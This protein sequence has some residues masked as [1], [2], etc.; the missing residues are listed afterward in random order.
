MDN[1]HIDHLL[2][3]IGNDVPKVNHLLSNKIYSKA[4]EKKQNKYKSFFF[5]PIVASMT[6]ALCMVLIFV[7]VI[8][9]KSLSLFKPMSDEGSTNNNSIYI[10]SL[11]PAESTTLNMDLQYAVYSNQYDVITVAVDNKVHNQKIYLKSY[12]Y[13]IL[14]VQLNNGDCLIDEVYVN[15]ELFYVVTFENKNATIHYFDICFEK[16]TFSNLNTKELI[17]FIVYVDNVNI[18]K[19]FGYE[20]KI[21]KI[22]SLS[23][24]IR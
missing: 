4:V 11:S 15:N 9:F 5:K 8:L 6:T 21:D 24:V 13:E 14:N 2:E 10:P 23:G 7:T 12:Q 17:N 20:F 16:G 1:N 22:Y 3:E 18:D 19:G